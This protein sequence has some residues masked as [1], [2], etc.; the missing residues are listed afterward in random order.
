MSA[1]QEGVKIPV[2]KKP[3]GAA[4]P[5]RVLNASDAVALI[6]GIVIGAG[7]FRTPSLVAGSVDSGGM[8]LSVWLVGGFISLIGALCYAELTTTFPNTEEIITF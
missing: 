7:I 8:L 2:E 1:F 3:E 4:G 5:G 6:V